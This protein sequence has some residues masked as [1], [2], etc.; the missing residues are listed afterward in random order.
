MHVG[1]PLETGCCRSELSVERQQCA[2]SGSSRSTTKDG[3][4]A[5]AAFPDRFRCRSVPRAP[6]HSPNRTSQGKIV[7][8]RQVPING[9][10]ESKRHVHAGI[11]GGR[12]LNAL[13]GD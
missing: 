1:R 3:A 10:I 13:H 12:A 11:S 8:G 4:A 5:L 9:K 6:E 7:H 2:Q